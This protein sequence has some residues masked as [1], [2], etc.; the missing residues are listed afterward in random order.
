MIPIADFIADFIA[1]LK[2]HPWGFELLR[3]KPYDR[4]LASQRKL[5]YL[6]QQQPELFRLYN[7]AEN[8]FIRSL[9]FDFQ[10]ITGNSVTDEKQHTQTQHHPMK[11]IFTLFFD[12]CVKPLVEA[13]NNL[14]HASGTTAP[15]PEAP[16]PV[17]EKPAKAAKA[18]PA[19]APAPEPG[20]RPP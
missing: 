7:H 17:A 3:G 2:T 19:P 12:I 18:K 14:A 1:L 15:V 20:R 10:S 5:L 6:C 4:G 9:P 11:E 16:A 13:I 8:R